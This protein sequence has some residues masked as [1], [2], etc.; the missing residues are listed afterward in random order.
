MLGL[1]VILTAGF[2]GFVVLLFDIQPGLAA[3]EPLQQTGQANYLFLSWS[4][5]EQTGLFNLLSPGVCLLIAWLASFVFLRN[6]RRISSPQLFFFLL[7]WISM[8]F[9][10]VRV[11]NLY[12]LPMDVPVS[13]HLTLSR[14]DTFGRLFASL[15][16]FAASLYATGVKLQ[17][18]GT[19]LAGIVIVAAVLSYLIPFDSNRVG[20]S[21]MYVPS[22]G[23]SL[24]AM[25]L[26]AG[27]L[28]LLNFIN[29]AISSRDSGEVSI[30]MPVIL[31]IVGHE[32][33]YASATWFGVIL[34]WISLAA[35]TFWLSR[36]FMNDFMWY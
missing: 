23:F 35:G 17:H 21:L 20:Q 14:V 33:V 15:S 11:L 16:L 7:F 24:D 5:S 18:Q 1:F 30:I 34:S 4:L 32:L 36:R 19:I 26:V 6:F 28:T 25:R 12:L 27:A 2:V 13:T 10:L 29:H 22:E 3:A 9:E 8:G 31:L